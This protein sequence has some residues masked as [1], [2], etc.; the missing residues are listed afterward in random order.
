MINTFAWKPSSHIVEH[1]SIFQIKNAVS[2][3]IRE[4]LITEIIEYKTKNEDFSGSEKN[5]WRGHLEFSD[6]YLN[7]LILTAVDTYIN[8]LPN[9]AILTRNENPEDRF[10][11]NCPL[12]HHWVNVNSKD[13][14]NISHNHAGSVISGVIYLQATQ[15]GIIEF[16][17]MNYIYKINHPCWF[18]NGSMQCHP[19]DGDIILFPSYLLHRVEPNPIEKERINIAFNISY[20]PK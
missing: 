13:G 17:P 9:S 15:T 16:Q 10:D 4:K 8:S 7:E 20:A 18:Y 2:S 5:C 11:Y 14:Y 6:G 19:E 1:T 3:S 12:I